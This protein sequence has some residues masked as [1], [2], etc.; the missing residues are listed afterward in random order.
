MDLVPAL[1]LC[2][3]RFLSSSLSPHLTLLLQSFYCSLDHLVDQSH[4][5]ADR[6]TV[7][8]NVLILTMLALHID[9]QLLS[10]HWSCKQCTIE[11]LWK[12][13]SIPINK[14]PCRQEANEISSRPFSPTVPVPS[15]LKATFSSNRKR[16]RILY[17]IV[18][19]SWQNFSLPPLLLPFNCNSMKGEL[20]HW[21][22]MWEPG[23]CGFARSGVL[24]M[25]SL[26]INLCLV[27]KEL[28]S[29]RTFRFQWLQGAQNVSNFSKILKCKGPNKVI[30][31]RI[32]QNVVFG[33]KDW[34][35]T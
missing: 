23:K 24:T 5:S 11:S 21:P 28:G 33:N 15:R 12:K 8:S 4:Y 14:L 26:C 27:G 2:N 29:R 10:P 9:H 1:S 20:L 19:V 35:Q 30:I 17:K 7:G 18:N 22:T 32:I 31:K 6:A 16:P 3:Q 25:T 34:S 13:I